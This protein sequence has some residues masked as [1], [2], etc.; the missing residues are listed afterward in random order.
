MNNN[1]SSLR[2]LLISFLN[3]EEGDS[4]W[5]V[6]APSVHSLDDLTPFEK[7]L[8]PLAYD[9]WRQSGRN[10]ENMQVLRGINRKTLVRN[11]L[12]LIECSKILQ[13]LRA[14]QIDVLVFKSGGL[15]GRLLPEKGVRAIADIDVWVRPS[16]IDLALQMLGCP[17]EGP[18]SS[19]HAVAI[20]LPSG[21]QLD[22]HVLPSHIYP[23]RF[24][25][26]QAGETLFDMAYRRS[27]AGVLSTSDLLYYSFLN[28]LFA[29]SPGE[30]RAAFALL[31]LNEAL[32]AS[33]MTDDVLRDVSRRIQDDQ[34]AAVFL[35]HYEWLGAGL[36]PN[37]D[38]FISIAVAPAAT[39][40]DLK[41]VRTLSCQVSKAKGQSEH[42]SWLRYHAR[43]H[44]LASRTPLTGRVGI[45]AAVV[46]RHY[47]SLRHN[48]GMLFLWLSRRKSWE[49]LWKI[50]R[51]I[52][53]V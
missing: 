27:D 44:L 17:G 24:A 3:K 4:G 6:L 39:Q 19:H 15:L 53:G 13:D 11:R 40:R 28:P 1:F 48:P 35:E 36:S 47:R 20:D 30:G 7:T 12:F 16:Q 25:T 9:R 52:M 10:V 8:L 22:L 51:D 29:H 33:S 31:E 50:G 26:K 49:R 32:S 41:L 45:Y 21:L 23:L 46:N 37:L 43:C 18:S 5:S 34:T 14:A 38:W 42:E 2:T